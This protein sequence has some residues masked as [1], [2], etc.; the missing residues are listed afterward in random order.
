MTLPVALSPNPAG[1]RPP[2]FAK[3]RAPLRAAGLVILLFFGVF[4]GWAAFA[5]LAGG[6]HAPGVV[7]PEGA[8]RTVQHLE[9]GIV[10]EIYVKDGD[11]VRLGQPLVLLAETRAQASFEILQHRR[12]TLLGALARM[13]AEQAGLSEIA[14][15]PELE[16]EEPAVIEIRAA[17]EEQFRSRRYNRRTRRDVLISRIAQLEQEIS[18]YRAL[19][20]SHAAQAGLIA[21]EL[22][23][24]KPLVDEGLAPV[25]RLLAL[26]RAQAQSRGSESENRAAIAR[27]TQAI[28]EARVQMLNLD[29]ELKS[30]LAAD[31]DKAQ[32][33]LA[34]V[35]QELAASRDVLDRT[36]IT[37]P[38]SGVV[39]AKRVTTIGGVVGPGE[40]LLEIVPS[41]DTL[42]I[43]ARVS[44]IDIDVVRA[45]LK[46]SVHLSAFTQRSLPQVSGAV[47]AVS[48]DALR[49]E[50]TGQSYYLAEVEVPASEMER[51]RARLGA[52]LELKPGMP[53]EVLIKTGERTLL[54]Y[55]FEPLAQSMR[56][57]LRET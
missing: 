21:E 33:E 41:E 51:V 13:R 38:V 49:D 25:S 57:A 5:P 2:L 10:K 8:R 52:D 45:G 17:Q 14:F 48:A 50:V 35:E 6:A 18:G 1:A 44:P 54:A 22:S 28:G 24:V 42:L 34:Q 27:A 55:L 4:G 9:G 19:V 12:R 29:S 3:L 23:T 20:Q 26:Q 16:G 36:Q 43:E 15:P 37:A 31:L 39:I 40:P 11:Q 56:R 46:A 47:R 32:V 7:S 30:E 53:A